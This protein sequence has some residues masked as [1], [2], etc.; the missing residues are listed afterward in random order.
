[1]HHLT[2]KLV[3]AVLIIVLVSAAYGIQYMYISDCELTTFGDSPLY[4]HPFTQGDTLMGPVHSNSLIAIYSSPQFYSLV[5]TT[6]CDFWRGPGY[7][8]GFHGPA[9]QFRAPHVDMPLM[10][11]NLRDGAMIQRTFYDEPFRSYR[12][13]LRGDSALVCRY[14]TGTPFDS[15]DTWMVALVMRRCMFFDGPLEILGHLSGQVSI[16]S[17]H[18]I[19]I[20]DN[21]RYDDADSLTGD[22][23]ESS[24]NLLALVSE[25]DIKI[26]NTPANGRWNSNGRGFNQTNPDS[27]SVIITAALYA[28]SEHFTFEQQNDID[29]GYVYEDPA[30][31]PHSDERGIIYLYGSLAQRRRG[32]LHRSSNTSTGYDL[33]MRYDPRLAHMTMPCGFEFDEERR[34][35]TDT[36]DFGTVPV[37]TTVWDTARVYLSVPGDLGSVIANTPFFATRVPPFHSDSFAIPT[38]F[39]P[40]RAAQFSGILYISAGTRY[41]QIVLRGRGMP[42]RAPVNVDISPNPFNL[43]TVIRYDLPESGA[44]KIV[45]YDILG[46]VARQVDL[47]AEGA[48]AHTL[49]LEANGLASG[50][51][52]INLH[53]AGQTITRKVLLLK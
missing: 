49:K 16:G 13:Y 17:S 3:F 42:A 5:S 34:P 43:T 48:G 33:H 25:H 35:S 44:V 29:S 26:A 6:E 28:L 15:S 32:Y 20:L 31:T 7:N 19:R 38:R 52:F 39:T 21:I 8:P 14:W 47:P 51:Y 24:P 27:T 11:E 1:M 22:T 53:A 50:V 12:V 2:Q 23:P 4:R 18:N 37:G 10:A 9:P 45:L 40:T 30:G 36:L 41:F 46:R